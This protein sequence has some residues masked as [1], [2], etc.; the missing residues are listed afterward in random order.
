MVIGVGLFRTVVEGPRSTTIVTAASLPPAR[1]IARTPARPA[2]WRIRQ[3]GLK[4][5]FD[6][7]FASIALL[8]S[9]PI[10][11]LI[12]IAVKLEDGG[13]VLFRQARWGR[14]GR[15]FSVFKF[16]SMA[17]DADRRFG[18]V[19]A[20]E[21]D[22]RVTRIGRLLR[23]TSLDELPQ[24]LNIWRGEMS[25]VGP[26]ALPMNELQRNERDSEPDAVVPGF[27]L[28][29]SVYPG[30][31]GLAQVFAARDVPRRL[32]FRY[33]AL[34]IKRQSL[35]LDLGLIVLSIWISLRGRWEDRGQ[36]IRRRRRRHGEPRWTR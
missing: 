36:K 8:A 30:L 4:R 24:V 13:P 12:A 7:S 3:Y 29:C 22:P 6:F 23:A 1:G 32:K 27:V 15:S 10:W 11:L 33:D 26:R 5:A 9:S 25:W 21:N 14:H 17:P 18:H 20:G 35:G 28:R 19:Q 2:T 31:T 34:Y 16:R